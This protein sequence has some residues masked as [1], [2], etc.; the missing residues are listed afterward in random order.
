MEQFIA[1][2]LNHNTYIQTISHR[3]HITWVSKK[4][5]R[6]LFF[7]GFI[8]FYWVKLGLVGFYWFFTFSLFQGWVILGFIQFPS[9]FKFFKAFFGKQNYEDLYHAL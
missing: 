7:W 5:L 9:T 4:N 3:V 2:T 6:V 8:G 1:R